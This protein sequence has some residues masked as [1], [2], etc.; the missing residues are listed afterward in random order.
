LGHE[1]VV[2]VTFSSE[3]KETLMTLEHSNLPDTE[4]ARGHD[5]GW[6]YFLEVFRDQFGA[7]SRR[8]YRWEEAH[9]PQAG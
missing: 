9:P 5:G 7:G 2:T 6:S 3:G 1:S 8:S 4:M